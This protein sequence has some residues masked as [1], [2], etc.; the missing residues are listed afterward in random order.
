[1]E[2]KEYIR[3]VR[4]R[5]WIVV[6]LAVLVAGAAFGFGKTMTPIYQASI[7]I[8]VR[9]ARA[10]W[11]LSNTVGAL[12]RSLAGDI[13]THQFLAKVIDRGALDTT[14]DDL[15]NGKTLFVKDEA[16]DFTITIT[17][18]D[19]NPKVATDMVN[20]IADIFKEERAKW[21]EEQDKRDRIDVE[22]RDYA[23]N[24]DLYS[25]KT[26]INM[27]AGSV[28]G[29]LV[30]TFIVFVWEWLEAGVIRSLED[31]DRL[32]IPALGAIPVES[33]RRRR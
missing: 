4:R 28:L 17:V 5:G 25:P 1:L 15:L 33:G 2:L 26:K 16:S 12:L 29:A 22:I 30:G 11:G 8:T 10:D 20:L 3:I 27:A 23:R 6:L 14:T 24:A 9:P 31:V 13:M 7:T 18:R 21:N 32:G 19:P